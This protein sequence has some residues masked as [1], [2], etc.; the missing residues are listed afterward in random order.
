M[1]ESYSPTGR[2][3]SRAVGV[4][5]DLLTPRCDS[6]L[7]WQDRR[8]KT[9]DKWDSTIYIRGH[10]DVENASVRKALNPIVYLDDFL[11]NS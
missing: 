6:N 7:T 8:K 10:N 3:E 11:Y 1:T 4:E 2:V 9:T 5:T